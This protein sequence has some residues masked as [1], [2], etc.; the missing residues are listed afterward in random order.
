MTKNKP[1]KTQGSSGAALRD[2]GYYS[3]ETEA[4]L[5]IEQFETLKEIEKYLKKEGISYKKRKPLLNRLG[6]KF[7]L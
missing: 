3:I 5:D 2:E 4:N 6:R 7:F 1:Q